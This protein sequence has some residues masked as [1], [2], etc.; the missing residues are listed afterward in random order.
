MHA[1]KDVVVVDASQA[2]IGPM[3]TQI[4]G[5]LGAEVIKIEQPGYG[6]L[7]RQ[8]T[9]DYKNLSAYFV[10]LNRNKRSLTL[11][12]KSDEGQEILHELI[13]DADIFFQN[14]GPNKA[15]EYAADYETLSSITDDLVYCD[16]SGYG[17]DSP[18]SNRKSF[19]IVLQG[20]SGMMGV[21]G[22]EDGDP[23]RTGV[24]ICDISA[25]M[26]STYAILTAIYHR[27]NTGEG[28]YIDISLLDTS[29]QF[30]LYHVT[31]YFATG[32]NPNRL[33]TKHPNLAPYQAIE[34][35]DSWI[36]VGVVSEKLWPAFCDAVNREEW[37]DDS[38][39]ATFDDRVENRRE[40]DIAIDEVFAQ[41]PT[42]EWISI[43]RDHD[44]PCSPVN[45]I[46]DI[47]EDPHIE[48]RGM[49]E[50]IEHSDLGTFKTPGNPVNFSNLETSMRRA[51]PEL[52]EHSV[53]VLSEL[54][55]S[56]E[57]IARFEVNEVI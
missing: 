28:Q 35:K 55:Y 56:D 14:F 9:P 3:A 47:V 39:F 22:T 15:P 8:Y 41:K 49:V 50:E 27:A 23:I 44:I 57:E 18:Y 25:A 48:A 1:L 40:F 31:N 42:E 4:L 45:T 5:D 17:Q 21:T 43:L 2:L 38:C 29:F 34:T 54:G 7:T 36:V 51:P 53:E 10:S 46:E 16:V 11:N 52:G 37:K 6:D 26:T 24:S 12:L 19:D 13:A 32:E 20:E 30:L 33:G